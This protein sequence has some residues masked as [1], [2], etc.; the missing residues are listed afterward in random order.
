MSQAAESALIEPNSRKR[1]FY[2][3]LSVAF[4]IAVF[5]GLIGELYG[6]LAYGD[7]EFDYY[8]GF[9]IGFSIGLASALI[10]IFYIRTQRRSWIRRVAFLPGLLVRIL[11]LTLMIRIALVGNM[12]LTDWLTGSEIM[13]QIKP[14]EQVRDTLVSMAFVLV[15]VILS[16]LTSIIGF[17]RFM[18]LVLGRYFRPISE[19]RVFMF[20]DLIGSSRL[21]RQ[22]G[23]VRFHQ[24]LSDFFHTL[25]QSIVR[26]GGEIVSYVGDAVIVTW[27]LSDNKKRNARCLVALKRMAIGMNHHGK[28]FESEYGVYPRFRAAVH[29][30]KVVVG[31]C[32][33]SRRQVTFLGDVVNITARIEDESKRLGVDYLVSQQ[34]LEVM[35]PPVGVHFEP[36]GPTKMKDIDEPITLQKVVL[37]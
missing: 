14:S 30:G 5:S 2:R 28:Y 37:S 12:V 7:Q 22:I 1:T 18:N 9:R 8:L 27:P 19:D 10:E 21:A 15:F 26:T 25:D 13:S 32:G 35:V 3:R 33:D 36:I 6:Y 11:V 31:E 17:K 29:G 16:Q 4:V 23:D 24:Y 20:V 34:M